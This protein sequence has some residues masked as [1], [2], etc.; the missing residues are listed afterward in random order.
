MKVVILGGGFCG[1]WVAK[2]LDRLNDL[3]VVLV[4]TKDYFEYSPSIWKLLLDTRMY[5]KIIVPH[6]R[7]LKRT[8]IVTDPLIQVTPSFV[9]TK[10]EKIRFDYLVISTGIDY[11]IFLKDKQNVFTVKSG[12]EV[13]KYTKKVLAAKTILIIGGGVIGSEVAA[14]L[15]THA[16]EKKIIVVHPHD[17]LLERNPPSV[18]RYAKKFLEGYGVQIIFD[19]KIVDHKKGVFLTSTNRRIKADLGIWCAGITC[20]PWFLKEFPAWIFTEK[21]S[22]KVNQ[23]LQLEGYP[24]I[25]IGGDIN[26]EDEE[27]TAAAADRQGIFIASNI[28]RMIAGKKLY[29]YAPIAFPMDISLG[30]YNGIIT[31]SPFMIPGVISAIIKKL[32]EI[33]GIA[34]L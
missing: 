29:K 18:S 3:D 8:R 28:P 15:A 24:H 25:Y 9:Q 13:M 12:T 10:K 4:D 30:R 34:R 1:A 14:E 17:R 16:P 19:E 6:T 5:P 20:N 11:P 22:L 2:K 23:Y 32:V 31:Y 7:Y 21:K 26:D 27:K 33:I